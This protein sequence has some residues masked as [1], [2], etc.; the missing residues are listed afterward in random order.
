M[1][2]DVK[3]MS[4]F[5][6]TNTRIYEAFQGIDALI[7]D[8]QNCGQPFVSAAESPISAIW[9][10]IYSTWMTNKIASQ[11]SEIWKT[12]SSWIAGIPTVAQTPAGMNAVSILIWSSA[13][14]SVTEQHPVGSLIFKMPSW[15]VGTPWVYKR[16]VQYRPKPRSLNRPHR[17][18][19]PAFQS[20]TAQLQI[21]R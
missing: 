18:P 6:N 20:Q 4:L 5:K 13:L 16:Q 8:K 10:S 11:N 17:A 12:A 9:G 2:Q 19:Q 21:H 15:P 14:S 1:N 7:V 3:V